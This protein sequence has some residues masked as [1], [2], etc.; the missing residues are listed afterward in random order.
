[1]SHWV[2]STIHLFQEQAQSGSGGGTPHILHEQYIPAFEWSEH[3]FCVCVL[4]TR[5]LNAWL[6]NQVVAGRKLN[7]WTSHAQVYG[8]GLSQE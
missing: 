3:P 4:G 1:M 7:R 2:Q 6:T 8:G 5:P